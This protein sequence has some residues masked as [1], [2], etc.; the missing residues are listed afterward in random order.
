MQKMN[1]SDRVA[2]L[3]K[4]GQPGVIYSR[5]LVAI[6]NFGSLVR[7]SQFVSQIKVAKSLDPRAIF[8][9]QEEEEC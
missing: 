6:A 2:L 7:R 5:L 3:A 8:E 9:F 4:L 1:D